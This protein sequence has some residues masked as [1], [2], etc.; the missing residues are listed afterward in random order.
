M[1]IIVNEG[2]GQGEK[3]RRRIPF[4]MGN[5]VAPGSERNRG[6]ANTVWLVDLG[7]V[8]KTA[9]GC[10]TARQPR[11]LPVSMWTVRV[12]RASVRPGWRAQD[13]AGREC[14]HVELLMK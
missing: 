1:Y 9:P 5:L 8:G 13:S 6:Y 12:I 14:I 7:V 4:Q 2:L 3:G 11:T 10:N